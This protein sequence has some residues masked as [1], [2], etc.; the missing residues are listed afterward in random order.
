MPASISAW[1]FVSSSGNS[2]PV[3]FGAPGLTGTASDLT[4][5]YLGPAPDKVGVDQ[6]NAL[7]QWKG[8]APR[9]QGAFVARTNLQPDRVL[10]F[11]HAA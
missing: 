2:A 9:V 6:A 3:T 1:A 10:Q 4:L 11:R 5:S 7:G 8:S